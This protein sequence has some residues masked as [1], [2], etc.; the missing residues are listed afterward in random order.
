RRERFGNRLPDDALDVRRQVERR[1][2]RTMAE[3]VIAHV[4]QV[5]VAVAANAQRVRRPRAAAPPRVIR[6]GSLVQVTRRIE[7]PLSSW[8]YSPTSL[9][10]IASRSPVSGLAAS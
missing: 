5:H 10:V 6:A 3:R 4:A 2:H 1:R 7:H 9:S 8:P